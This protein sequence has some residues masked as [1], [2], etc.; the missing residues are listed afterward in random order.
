MIFVIIKKII[1]FN[2][3]YWHMNPKI[4]KA[5]D[6]NKTKKLT[7]QEIWDF[8]KRKMECAEEH[9]YK[10][11]YIWESEYNESRSAV[12]KKCME[13]FNTMKWIIQLIYLILEHLNTNSEE[14]LIKSFELTGI[15]VAN[16]NGWT[17]ATHIHLTKPF[18]IYKLTLE[19]G[20]TL[21]CADEH[22][23]FTKDYK[24]KWVKDLT[25]NDYVI[26]Q[27]GL[28]KVVSVEANKV[29]LSIC[30]I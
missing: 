16:E 22:I 18:E 11:L 20:L 10:V 9:G 12:I 23:V 25:E 2:G 28:S 4:Y 13:F 26:T 14:K 6:I 8:D 27:Y 7:A 3:D 24:E 5:N 17:N 21:E 19:N 30:V 29:N 1:E 15:S